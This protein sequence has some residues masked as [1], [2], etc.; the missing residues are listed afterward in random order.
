MKIKIAICDDEEIIRK[1]LVNTITEY[2]SLKNIDI[3]LLNI[4][5]GI[6]S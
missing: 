3:E 6:H 1:Q 2:F 4:Q 5:M